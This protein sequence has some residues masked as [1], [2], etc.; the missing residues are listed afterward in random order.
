MNNIIKGVLKFPKNYSKNNLEYWNNFTGIVEKIYNDVN[1]DKKGVIANYIPELANINDDL[2]GISIFSIDGVEFNIGDTNTMISLQSCSKPITYGI[3]LEEYGEDIVHNFVG[4]EPSGRNFNELCLNSDGLP[5]N[6]LINAGAIMCTS[7]ILPNETQSK[8]FNFIKS[9]W[10]KLIDDNSKN[11]NISFNNSIYLSEKETADRNYCL[12]YMMQEKKAF[13]NGIN[14]Q[15]Q[16]EWKRGDLQ[17]N[18][19]LYFQ[20]CSLE[21]KLYNVALMSATLANKGINPK[22][23][24]Q[25]FK[26]NN[27][28]NILS[29]MLTCGMYDYSG[30]WIYHIGIPAKSGVSGLIYGVVPNK[31]GIAVY[32]PKL[33][34]LG[35]SHKGIEFFK[36]L[37]LE[38]DIHI[39][40]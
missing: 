18:L 23:G 22:T 35:N 16:R 20:I 13:K 28:K 30:E 14:N 9:F 32:S 3:A 40:N 39:F 19:E 37:S 17:N 29:L 34:R 6:P 5:H 31:M 12:G 4:K 27:L 10:N 7:L 2:F 26:Y 33:D 8:R 1:N 21:L 11:Q 36:K 24:N 15:L 25:I 38:T